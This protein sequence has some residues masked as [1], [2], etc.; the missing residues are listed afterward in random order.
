M[1]VLNLLILLFLKDFNMISVFIS[2]VILSWFVGEEVA[3]DVVRHS[4]TI[5]AN[6]VGQRTT[7]SAALD[8]NVYLNTVRQYC[9]AAAWLAIESVV[10]G[11]KRDVTWYCAACSSTIDSR[12]VVCECCLQWNHFGCVG[13]KSLPKVR[14]WFCSQCKKG[15]E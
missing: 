11:V 6:Q 7:T 8:E 1:Q 14:S 3:D 10:D 15:G 5:D 4:G 9:D 2:V 13:L 12:S